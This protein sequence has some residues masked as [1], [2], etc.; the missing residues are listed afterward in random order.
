MKP[1][2]YAV[3]QKKIFSFSV[4]LS[5]TGG[6]VFL[7]LASLLQ[8]DSQAAMP[9][10]ITIKST[11]NTPDMQSEKLV[12][13]YELLHNRLNSLQQMDEQYASL[14]KNDAG[15]AKIDSLNTIIHQEEDFYTA[16]L[17]LINQ[18]IASFTDE[19][20]KKQFL[21]MINSFRAAINYRESINRLRDEIAF[22]GQVQISDTSIS[23]ELAQELN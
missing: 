17:E 23:P 1:I 3:R 9:S 15:A 4:L 13:Y 10:D 6:I 16:T 22:K 21:K 18:H 14:V 12:H 8:N 5:V 19:A 20:K 11:A 2:N 7:M